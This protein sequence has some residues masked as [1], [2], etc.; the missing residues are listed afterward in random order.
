MGARSR[1]GLQG[2]TPRE[3]SAF[4]AFPLVSL[5]SPAPPL[6][7]A[8]QQHPPVRTLIM[9]RG[10]LQLR[11][12][13]VGPWRAAVAVAAARGGCQPAWRGALRNVLGVDMCGFMLI[14]KCS[15]QS[16]WIVCL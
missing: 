13:A 10:P 1:Q 16:A 8:H 15:G 4:I 9:R 3:A 14:W 2:E 7:P 6:P 5:A 11:L 12:G